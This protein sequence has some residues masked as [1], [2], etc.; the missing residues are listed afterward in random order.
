TTPDDIHG[1]V[2][3]EAIVTSRGGMT[4]HAAVVARGMGKACIAGCEALKISISDREF[5]AGETTVKEG[6]IV[7]VDGSTWDIILGDIPRIETELSEE[8]RLLL[9]WADN[10]KRLTVRANADNKTD[11]EKALDFGAKGIGL[12]RTEHMFMEANRS[13]IVQKMILSSDF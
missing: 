13:E 2:A 12:C 7:T 11:A 9:S 6:E 3:S 1:M 4:S 8:F 5:S 10:V